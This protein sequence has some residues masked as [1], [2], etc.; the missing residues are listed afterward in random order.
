MKLDTFGRAYLTLTLEIEKHIEGY[1]DAYTG[2]DD[3]KAA[4]AATPKREPAA[5]LD[6]LAWLQAHIPDGD[7]ARATYLTAV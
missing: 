1:I 6:D 3:L 2:P 5:L 7:A 4:V